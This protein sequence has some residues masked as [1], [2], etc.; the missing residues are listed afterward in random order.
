V[1]PQKLQRNLRNSSLGAFLPE[2]RSRSDHIHS[3][4]QRIVPLTAAWPAPIP[5]P[6][7]PRVHRE[8]T[9][10]KM[11]IRS[12]L[13]SQSCPVYCAHLFG[14]VKS[15]REPRDNEW[16]KAYR[17]SASGHSASLWLKP[18]FHAKF[19]HILVYRLSASHQASTRVDLARTIALA[20]RTLQCSYRASQR[21]IGIDVL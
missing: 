9:L 8:S 17:G 16:D 15:R 5:G 12:V 10:L 19:R 2:G 1:I 14:Q 11:E 20:V 3:P 6:V 4:L 13:G 21:E 7:A 18:R